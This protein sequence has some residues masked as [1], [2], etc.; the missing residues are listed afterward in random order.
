MTKKNGLLSS[1]ACGHMS[2]GGPAPD[3]PGSSPGWTLDRTGS[4]VLPSVIVAVGGDIF[5]RGSVIFVRGRSSCGDILLPEKK[6]K[7]DISLDS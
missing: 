3:T 6:M 1:L 4:I 7:N 2:W 5:D